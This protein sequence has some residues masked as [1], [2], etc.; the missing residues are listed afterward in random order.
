[1]IFLSR[2]A[3]LYPHF[4]LLAL[5][6]LHITILTLQAIVR[7]PIKTIKGL[8]YKRYLETFSKLHEL[9]GP[10]SL[11]EFSNIKSSVNPLKVFEL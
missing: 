10:C 6:K 11:K 2:L 3:W 4:T 1:M 8:H 7:T 9:L 5:H